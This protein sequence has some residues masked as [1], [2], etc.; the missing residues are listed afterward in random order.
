[1]RERVMASE[2]RNKRASRSKRK[3]RCEGGLGGGESEK[4]AREGSSHLVS[5]SEDGDEHVDE[6]EED[7]YDK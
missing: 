7:E 2:E 1:M 5:I 4:A 3:G 6:D